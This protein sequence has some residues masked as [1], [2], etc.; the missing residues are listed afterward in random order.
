MVP[1]LA[2]PTQTN[3]RYGAHIAIPSKPP[4]ISNMGVRGWALESACTRSFYLSCGR[5]VCT[6]R[7]AERLFRMTRVWLCMKSSATFRQVGFKHNR[8]VDVAYWQLVL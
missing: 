5:E 8:W 3:G 2:M 4:S 1:S 7:S 6:L